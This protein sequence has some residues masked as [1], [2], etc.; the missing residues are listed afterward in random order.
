MNL[1]QG[2]DWLTR[3]Q[4]WLMARV[5]G[6]VPGPV[7]VT[8]YRKRFFGAQYMECTAEALRADSEWTAHERELFAAFVSRVNQCPY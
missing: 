3:A 6:Q 4:F 8:A 7:R 2:G 5:I 1:T